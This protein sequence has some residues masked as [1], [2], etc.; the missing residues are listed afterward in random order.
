[1]TNAMKESIRIIPDY[2]LRVIAELAE[3]TLK[4]NAL[5]RFIGSDKFADV[6]SDEQYLLTKQSQVMSDYVQVLADR[7]ELWNNV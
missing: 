5:D 4:F 1:M 7:M 3:L 6:S 2:Q